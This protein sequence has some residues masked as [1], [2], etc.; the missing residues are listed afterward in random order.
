M[1]CMSCPAAAHAACLDLDRA[2]AGDWHCALC[3]CTACGHADFV[4]LA[5]PPDVQQVGSLYE[6][7]LRVMPR[8]WCR[9]SALPAVPF[10]VCSR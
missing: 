6:T 1:L 5:G 2:P 10:Q 4:G 8:C 9:P 3:H 7:L